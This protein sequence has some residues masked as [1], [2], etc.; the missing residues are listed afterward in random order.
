[1]KYYYIDF[2]CLLFFSRIDITDFWDFVDIFR[3]K[4]AHEQKCLETTAIYN[5]KTTCSYNITAHRINIV[6]LIVTLQKRLN[7]K[8]SNDT[9]YFC[10]L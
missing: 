2:M 8:H 9:Q 1:M 3:Y 7:Y 6:L 10:F 5:I 4:R